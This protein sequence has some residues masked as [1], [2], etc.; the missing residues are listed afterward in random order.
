METDICKG[1]NESQAAGSLR[2]PYWSDMQHALLYLGIIVIGMV[3]DVQRCS[4]EFG[5]FK[6]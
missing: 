5:Y 1:D 4:G 3:I 2:W 6:N